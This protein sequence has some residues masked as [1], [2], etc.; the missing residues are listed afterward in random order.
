[1]KKINILTECEDDLLLSLLAENEN[2]K[3]SF[4]YFNVNR[5][6]L[7]ANHI[8]RFRLLP[9][10]EDLLIRIKNVTLVLQIEE[11]QVYQIEDSGNLDECL[12]IIKEEMEYE[13]SRLKNKYRNNINW[14]LLV[15]T[16][17]NAELK[18]FIK[19]M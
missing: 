7:L 5:L 16:F 12:N 13:I 17:E 11:R 19:T 6:F 1:M 2:V 14:F 10:L 4:F 15:D 18:E 9:N 3:P 8:Q